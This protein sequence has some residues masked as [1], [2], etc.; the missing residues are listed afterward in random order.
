MS[1]LSWWRKR[2]GI[3]NEEPIPIYQ[4][5]LSESGAVGFALSSLSVESV[6]ERFRESQPLT[7]DFIWNLCQITKAKPKGFYH[8]HFK[9]KEKKDGY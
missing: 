5:W 6:C 8:Y 3:L 1:L 9:L 2:Q 7:P 4:N